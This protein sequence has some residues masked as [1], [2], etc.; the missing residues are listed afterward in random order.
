MASRGSSAEFSPRAKVCRSAHAKDLLEH[1]LRHAV[2]AGAQQLGREVGFHH[3]R[4]SMPWPEDFLVDGEDLGV[5]T[6]G[7]SR[8][9]VRH[10]RT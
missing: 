3:Q 5:L 10:G 7:L 2:L 9:D 6:A 4:L 8:R 1:G